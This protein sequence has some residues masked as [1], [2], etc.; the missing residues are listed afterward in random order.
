MQDASEILAVEERL[1]KQLKAYPDDSPRLQGI[2]AIARKA[3]IREGHG[4]EFEIRGTVNSNTQAVGNEG[5]L[6]IY[7]DVFRTFPYGLGSLAKLLLP[8]K[9]RLIQDTSQSQFVLGA[10]QLSHARIDEVLSH[11][12]SHG[13]I[14]FVVE[15]RGRSPDAEGKDHLIALLPTTPSLIARSLESGGSDIRYYG[16]L[17][18]FSRP[19]SMY[20]FFMWWKFPALFAAGCWLLLLYPDTARRLALPI[21]RFPDAPRLVDVLPL[22]P[23]TLDTA[24]RL[25]QLHERLARAVA[26]PQPDPAA[27]AEILRAAEEAAGKRGGTVSEADLLAA[28]DALRA[29]AGVADRVLALL[30]LVN[31]LWLSAI[32]GIAVSV[33]P[34]LHFLLPPLR[35]ALA[36]ACSWL[37]RRVL[38]PVAARLHRWGVLEAAAYA[39][40]WSAVARGAVPPRPFGKGAGG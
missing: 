38:V 16:T 6:N 40:C 26:L 17:P 34:S 18:A 23:T 13:D 32:A 24:F 4:I 9:V 14:P 28:G 5:S 11:T 21:L 35:A 29:A 36:R 7:G 3:R 22:R 30:S 33:G 1:L 31:L 37:L 25:G 8:L 2:S 27:V 39:L 20:E 15:L 10:K 19:S 12:V